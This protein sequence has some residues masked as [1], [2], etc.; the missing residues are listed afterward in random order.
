MLGLSSTDYLD[1]H[2]ELSIDVS[3][4]PSLGSDSVGNLDIGQVHTKQAS[5]G[6][7]VTGMGL[8]NILSSM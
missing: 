5:S 8:V 7:T 6:E 4:Y 1:V 3:M 2:S